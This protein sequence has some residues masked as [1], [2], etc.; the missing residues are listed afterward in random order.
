MSNA[1]S[2]SK[3]STM[4]K[5]YT[6]SKNSTMSNANSMSKNST[7][8]KTY[9]MSKDSTVS[10]TNSMSKGN[11]MSKNSRV[12]N[13]MHNWTSNK[14]RMGNSMSNCMSNS[15]TI[16]RDTVISHISNI[17]IVVIGMVVDSL[18]AATRKVDG[19]RALDN[20]GTIIGLSLVEGS[21]RVVISNS[22]GVRV[23]R[24]LSKV[25]LGISSNSTMSNHSVSKEL[26]GSR[27][28]GDESSKTGK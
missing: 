23:G 1:N 7:M 15:F 25:R 22:I 24:D 8:S 17:S 13:S 4:S 19:V 21:T 11:S 20:T 10:K 16:G 9:T 12:S 6:M 27:C 14:S 3:N 18:D 28:C 2:M 5:T 26:G